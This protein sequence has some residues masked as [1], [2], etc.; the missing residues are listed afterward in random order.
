MKQASLGSS[1]GHNTKRPHFTRL[2][3]HDYNDLQAKGL[4]FRCKKPYT[5]GHKCPLK[6]LQVLLAEEGD[7]LDFNQTDFLEMAEFDSQ[8]DPNEE[9]G[10]EDGSL[11][12]FGGNI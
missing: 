12:V 11:P 3:P 2:T 5:L 9:L 4:C 6:Q 1:G 10:G 8:I 7:D